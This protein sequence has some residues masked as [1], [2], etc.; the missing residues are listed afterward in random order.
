MQ[1]ISY[2][3][4]IEIIR[5]KDKVIVSIVR[6]EN[7][8]KYC[9]FNITKQHVCRCR[10]DSIEDAIHDLETREEVLSYRFVKLSVCIN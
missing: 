6:D 5:K 9:F 4:I 3:S 7:T 8:N 2:D 1:E 10:F